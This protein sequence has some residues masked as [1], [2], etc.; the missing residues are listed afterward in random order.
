MQKIRHVLQGLHHES[1]YT[2]LKQALTQAYSVSRR[3]QI[4]ELLYHTSLG[5][6]RPTE[7]LAHMRELVGT[8]DSPDLL[9][10]LFLDRLHRDV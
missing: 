9:E 2:Q 8:H 6:R 5:D 10:K 1:P 3:K 7:M 4:D